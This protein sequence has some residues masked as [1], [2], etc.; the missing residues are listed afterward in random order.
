MGDIPSYYVEECNSL[1]TIQSEHWFSLC[2]CVCVCVCV[3]NNVSSS[4]R[5]HNIWAEDTYQ[6]IEMCSIVDTNAL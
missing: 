5:Q 3:F 4:C 2:V 6:C 1:K